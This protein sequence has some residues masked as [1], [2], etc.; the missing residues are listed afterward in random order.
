[1]KREKPT[2]PVYSHRHARWL[3]AEV[4]MGLLGADDIVANPDGFVHSV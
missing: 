1:M 4:N 2:D 3:S